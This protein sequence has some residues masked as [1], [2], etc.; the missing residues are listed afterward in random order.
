MLTISVRCHSAAEAINLVG[1]LSDNGFAFDGTGSPTMT[2]PAPTTEEPAPSGPPAPPPQST[3][4]A[5]PAAPERPPLT[6]SITPKQYDFAISLMKQRGWTEELANEWFAKD[7]N[8]GQGWG[9]LGGLAAF[10]KEDASLLIDG[11]NS[12]K[13]GPP[14]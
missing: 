11:F 7:R 1:L 9:V 5:T 10:S 12:G 2:T 8:S 4:P 13:Y 6:G 14:F 3:A